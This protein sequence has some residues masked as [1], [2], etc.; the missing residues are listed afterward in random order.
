MKGKQL[1]LAISVFLTFSIILTTLFVSGVLPVKAPVTGNKGEGD[2]ENTISDGDENL[3]VPGKS[4]ISETQGDEEDS[5][6]T[7]GNAQE[8]IG[9]QWVSKSSINIINNSPEYEVEMYLCY[10]NDKLPFIEVEYYMQGVSK[11]M[12]YSASEIPALK[13]FLSDDNNKFHISEGILN[14]KYAKLYFFVEKELNPKEILFDFYV[15]SLKDG[16]VKKLHGGKGHGFNRIT[17]SPD[18]AHAAYSYLVGDEG[19]DSFIQIFNCVVDNLLV[20][21]N[22]TLDGKA[23]GKAEDN[24]RIY[25]Y[26]ILRW[27]SS[28]E[29]RLKEYSYLWNKEKSTRENESEVE[30]TFNIKMGR[31]IY[32][33]DKNKIEN[34]G[35]TENTASPENGD[36]QAK[37]EQEGKTGL[38][39]GISSPGAGQDKE[40]PEQEETQKRD[41]SETSSNVEAVSGQLP[42]DST[43]Q[44]NSN[45]P[46]SGNESTEGTNRLDE[47]GGKLSY[48]E[49]VSVLKSFYEYVN[50]ARYEE[51]YNLVD[52]KIRFNVLKKILEQMF[53][54]VE[55]NTEINKSDIDVK[56]FAG[57]IETTG[58]FKNVE[59]EEIIKEEKSDTIS[60][61][62]YYHTMMMDETS[63]PVTMP[64]IATLRKTDNGWKISAFDDG[65]ANSPPFK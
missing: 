20:A 18:K 45:V 60:K 62:Y 37:T 36:E 24:S 56:F 13:E 29:L 61:V 7:K 12:L 30:V 2:N 65:D 16:N 10:D 47:T 46:E 27:R 44:E 11:S 63:W 64:I 28:E 55:V 32:P 19:K 57:L 42:K 35:N 34:E 23:I 40:Q 4:G 53:Q 33:E 22:K 6:T 25:S 59:I 38:Q 50:N 31:V 14:T 9:Y 49:A 1:Y 52:E 39:E 15:L 3:S 17:F 21:D 58:M 48:S 8:E 26:F 5:E 54:G 51:A 43:P 41:Q